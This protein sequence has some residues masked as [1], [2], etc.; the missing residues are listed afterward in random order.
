MAGFD[1][2]TGRAMHAI[3]RAGQLTREY[4]HKEIEPGH[5]LLGILEVKGRA[6]S[7]LWDLGVEADR[8]RAAIERRGRFPQRD[9]TVPRSG[10]SAFSERTKSVLAAATQLSDATGIPWVGTEHILL[11]LI[12]SDDALAGQVLKDE[13]VTPDNVRTLLAGKPAKAKPG[14]DGP[15]RRGSPV[16][17][18]SESF[19]D[20]LQGRRPA[21]KIVGDDRQ[22]LIAACMDYLTPERVAAWNFDDPG[23]GRATWILDQLLPLEEVELFRRINSYERWLH[24]LYA[25]FRRSPEDLD[26]VTPERFGNGECI[27]VQ[28]AWTETRETDDEL[29]GWQ[30]ECERRG[31][32]NTNENIV[33]AI[34][35][36]RRTPNLD[37]IASYLPDAPRQEVPV[38]LNCA[39]R[40]AAAVVPRTEEPEPGLQK[41]L[42]DAGLEALA[43]AAAAVMAYAPSGP[44]LRVEMDVGTR[45]VDVWETGF[46]E[47]LWLAQQTYE[48]VDRVVNAVV[49]DP[50]WQLARI[51]PRDRADIWERAFRSKRSPGASMM[52]AFCEWCTEPDR[53]LL[54]QH[55]DHE[56]IEWAAPALETYLA[57]APTAE[58]AHLAESKGRPAWQVEVLDRWLHAPSELRPAKC[59]ARCPWEIVFDYREFDPFGA[60]LHDKY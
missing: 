59:R 39:M 27:A 20:L 34:E 21:W 7:L 24:T 15:S 6:L 8:I 58:V 35:Y 19:D 49:R 14:R 23:P 12:E 57:L 40:L 10:S 22:R 55:F 11:A 41:R 54:R 33:A 32:T 18:F 45:D 46:A 52:H 5:L 13:S 51:V 44:A 53:H 31:W 38:L 4:G 30:G 2:Y 29:L 3:G 43:E 26:S 60:R 37:R 28:A 36:G 50:A 9:E 42:A 48:D 17:N 1:S 56:D 16:S 25:L 47:T